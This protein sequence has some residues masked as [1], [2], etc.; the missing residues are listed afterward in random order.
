LLSILGQAATQRWGKET[1]FISVSHLFDKMV[2][3]KNVAVIF[4]DEV[5]ELF[6]E[7]KN[8]EIEELNV[9]D[10]DNLRMIGL[11]GTGG[12]IVITSGS[13]SQL[14][15]LLRPSSHPNEVLKK[16]YPHFDGSDCN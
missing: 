10:L 8:K 4:A 6:K 3:K 14:P 7:A 13:S 2:E 9:I 16:N 12:A 15:S 11:Q 5:Q 1:Y